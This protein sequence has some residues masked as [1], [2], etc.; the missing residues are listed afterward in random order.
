MQET[1]DYVIVGSGFGGSVSAMRLAEKG[2]SVLVLEKGKRLDDG[3]FAK[4]NLAF[5]KY[6]WAPKLG[7]H[8]VL[9]ISLLKGMMVLHGTGVG[10]GSLGYANVLEVPNEAT[11]ATPAWNAPLP[12]GKVLA[13]HY[14]TAKRMLGVARNP[15]LWKADETLRDI[16]E[17]LGRGESFRATEVGSWFGDPGVRVPDPYFG[18]EG[19]EREGCTHCGGCMVG[20]RHNAKN[21]LPKN[22]LYF[23]ERLGA[24][25]RHGSKVVD[26][27][28]LEG[29]GGPSGD[30]A[31]YELRFRASMRPSFGTRRVRARNVIFSAGV[32]GTMGLLLKL[33]DVK[34]SLPAL[35]P[36]LGEKVR[37]NSESLLGSIARKGGT[38]WSEGVAISSI[39]NADEVTRVEPVRYPAG[40]DLMRFI[41]APLI[42]DATSVPARLF[43]TFAWIFTNPADFLRAMVVPGWAKRATILLIMQ[44][45]D[46]GL[47]L[48]TGRSWMTRGRRGLVAEQYGA[49]GSAS[50]DV[51]PAAAGRAG[52][53]ASAGMAG[54]AARVDTGHLVTREFSKRID[55]VNLG[56][57][58]ENAFNMPTTAH[59]LGGA[60]IGSTSAEGAVDETFTLHNY[61][62]LRIID[63]SIVPANPGVNPSLSI[64]ALAEYAM[65]GVPP[66]SATSP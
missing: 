24:K 56:S 57:V 53:A 37:T 20:C 49:E 34:K 1:W 51:A 3:D 17:S 43:R 31:R 30:G 12:W 46:N 32:L 27:R 7:C 2:Y 23:A 6:L 8:G 9:E 39:F 62:G 33:R 21:T 36:M 16:A 61:P 55:G 42:S 19:P 41:G 54:L 28:P 52:M 59:I 13:E 22:Y 14:A 35:S 25:I 50:V 10:G 29:T 44:N 64:A 38:D 58:A 48:K 45:I 5:W 4:S 47:R 40:S 15:K 26:V 18:G 66:K 60:P 63:G 11:F 65:A